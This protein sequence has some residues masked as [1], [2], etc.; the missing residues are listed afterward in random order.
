MLIQIM[1]IQVIRQLWLVVV[2]LYLMPLSTTHCIS[3]ISWQSI[4]LVEETGVSGE[5]H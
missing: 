4:L 5:N 2:F 1:R 3:I